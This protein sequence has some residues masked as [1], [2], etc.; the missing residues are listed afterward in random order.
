MKSTINQ[1]IH[2]SIAVKSSLPI[3]DIHTVAMVLIDTLKKGHKLVV[4]GNGGSAADAQHVTAE[5]TGRFMRDR[6]PLPA[7]ALTSNSSSITAIGNDYGFDQVFSRQLAALA[8]PN[9]VFIGIST[10]GQSENLIQA[11]EYAN[12]HSIP[13]ISLTGHDGGRLQSLATYAVNVPSPVTARIQEAHILIL[14]IWCQLV[15]EALF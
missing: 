10:S 9:D 5:F 14:H 13:T 7:I 2:D 15:E 8:Q 4:A 1:L 6:A 11:F 3:D 12:T